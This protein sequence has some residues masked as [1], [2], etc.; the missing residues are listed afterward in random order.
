MS[1]LVALI[2]FVVLTGA[3]VFF[4]GIMTRKRTIVLS[5]SPAA[6]FVVIWF[7]L[8]TSRPNP[9][10]EFDRLFGATNRGAA[11]DIRP[12]KPT[13]MDGHFI[14]FRMRRAD[15]DARIRPQFLEIR[16]ASSPNFLLS[17]SLPD[18]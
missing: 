11:S 17:Q 2:V 3:A 5:S 8:A 14:S 18:G 16:S 9:E 15:F 10:K 7:F 1:P 4:V 12:L 13:L 6:V